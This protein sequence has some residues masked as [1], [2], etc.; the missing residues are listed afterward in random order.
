LAISQSGK[1]NEIQVLLPILKRE[2]ILII[3]MTGDINSPLAQHADLVLPTI[4]EQE[5][6]PNNL[7]PT[8][9][10]TAALVLGDA[11]SVALLSTRGFSPQ[12]FARSHPGGALGKRLLTTVKNV[13]R[14]YEKTPKVAFNAPLNEVLTEI[15][16]H[17]LGMTAVIDEQQI[18]LGIITDGDI[19][20]MLQQPQNTDAQS[21]QNI[22]AADL[23]KNHRSPITIKENALMEEVLHIFE[24]QKINQI[25][26]TN[27]SEKLCG[28]FNI[29]DLFMA[30]VL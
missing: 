4:I 18:V 12:D 25:I 6:C 16:Q 11:L 13:M 17:Q 27:D 19:R 8:S 10:T 2:G 24:K 9:S 14:S 26:V 22:T 23:I 3:A 7:A 21:L 29:H 15:T 5:A 30:K 20:R 28:A 1:S